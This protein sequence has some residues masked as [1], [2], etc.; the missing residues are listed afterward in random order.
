MI[1]IAPAGSR[2]T[3]YYPVFILLNLLNELIDRVVELLES[4]CI[5]S[6]D[7]IDHAGREML[8]EDDSADRID[9]GLYSRELD[10]DLRAVS[11][12]FDHTLGG[13]H[14]PDDP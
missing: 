9:S 4:S 3:K 11:S 6:L 10:Q 14:V 2:S 1:L 13:L 5:V 8:L 7:R 12:V